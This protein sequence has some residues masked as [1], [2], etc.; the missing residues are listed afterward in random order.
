MFIWIDSI[1]DDIGYHY[2]FLF[3]ELS[4][5]KIHNNLLHYIIHIFMSIE[6]TL[7]LVGINEY[8][9]VLQI[10]DDIYFFYPNENIVSKL[11]PPLDWVKPYSDNINSS[12]LYIIN[13][14][15]NRSFDEFL[16]TME[17]N[18]LDC[19]QSENNQLDCIQ[20]ENI[21][22]IN[23]SENIKNKPP[24]LKKSSINKPRFKF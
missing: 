13:N 20:S 7:Y 17:Y 18:Q 9:I 4:N 24:L 11:K 3:Y 15:I 22:S 10:K 2:Q 12:K 1:K 8:Y 6:E 16:F 14:I 5:K 19:I 21:Q 23:K